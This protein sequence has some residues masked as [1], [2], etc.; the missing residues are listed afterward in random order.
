ATQ[1]LP[2]CGRISR[3]VPQ[4]GGAMSAVQRTDA[5]LWR[6]LIPGRALALGVAA[7]L[8]V[9]V[10]VRVGR[11]AAQVTSTES[12]VA[13]GKRMYREGLLP[14]GQPLRATV[15]GDIPLAGTQFTC[16]SCHRWSGLGAS[17]SAV[18]V[19]PVT[20]PAL[21]RASE[22]RRADLFRKL[23]QEPQP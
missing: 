15:Q 14:S 12:Q 4:A 8:L 19:P 1:W 22:L 20:G 18:F 7:A 23:F 3:R 17:D 13:W 11:S 9:S 10:G 2:E 16:A 6:R 21:Y 5:P